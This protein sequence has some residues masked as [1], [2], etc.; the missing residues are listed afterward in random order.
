MLSGHVGPVEGAQDGGG[1]VVEG[2]RRAVGIGV[3]EAGQGDREGARA[4]QVEVLDDLVP[5]PGAEPVAG[6]EDDGRGGVRCDH[7]SSLRRSLGTCVSL[8]LS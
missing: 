4:V 8:F 1:L 2:P 7:D 3:V 6:D 5:G